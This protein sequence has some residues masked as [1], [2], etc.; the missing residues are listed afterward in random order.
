MKFV[1]LILSKSWLLRTKTYYLATVN[2]QFWLLNFCSLIVKAW[3][4][5]ERMGGNISYRNLLCKVHSIDGGM[6]HLCLPLTFHKYDNL[7][8]LERLNTGIHLSDVCIICIFFLCLNH[9]QMQKGQKKSWLYLGLFPFWDFWVVEQE[10]LWFWLSF[11]FHVFFN[12]YR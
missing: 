5:I 10:E 1:F 2:Y 12:E 8:E 11:F 3:R 6:D 7:Y 4:P 9:H